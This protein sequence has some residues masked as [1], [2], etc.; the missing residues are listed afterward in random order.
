MNFAYVRNQLWIALRIARFDAG[1][2]REFDHSIDGFFRSFVALLL[3]A[4]LYIF[5]VVAQRRLAAAAPT[6]MPDLEFGPVLPITPGYVLFEAFAYL[7]NWLAFPIALIFIV[8]LIKAGDRYVPFI[9]AYNWTACV[10]VFVSFVPQLLYLAGVLP[11]A[12]VIAFYIPILI[13]AAAYEWLVAREAL[14]ISALTAAGIV[15][16]DYL[17]SS[18]VGRVFERIVMG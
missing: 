4:P 10:V 18:L 12:V 3:C 16:I 8:R 9:I 2:V 1:A 14:G 11:M 17:L 15:L 13:F 6:E 7:A 5:I